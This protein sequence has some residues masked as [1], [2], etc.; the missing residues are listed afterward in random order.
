MH[1]LTRAS[2][3]PGSP[4]YQKVEKDG[5]RERQGGME[6]GMKEGGREAA[7]EVGRVREGWRFGGREGAGRGRKNWVHLDMIGLVQGLA[8]L[9][10]LP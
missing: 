2:L 3:G 1:R 4:R 7:E 6:G 9:E 10:V 8:D 5:E